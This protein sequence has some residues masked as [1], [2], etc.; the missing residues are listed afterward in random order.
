[1]PPQDFAN[2]VLKAGNL[3]ALIAD[4]RRN[5]AL[6]VALEAATITDASGNPIDLSA[7]SAG[8]LAEISRDDELEDDGVLLAE[9]S[10][11]E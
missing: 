10:D 1:M 2:E 7:L 4:V 9:D 11:E 8:D 5:K 6:A 3:P